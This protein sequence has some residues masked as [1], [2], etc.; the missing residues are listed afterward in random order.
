MNAPVR[1]LGIAFLIGIAAAI[2]VAPGA[3]ADRAIRDLGVFPGDSG[4]VALGINEAGWV[5]G[6]G[7]CDSCQSYTTYR[8]LLWANSVITDFGNLG[9]GTYS[10]AAAI[11]NVGQAVG[12]S[13]NA[14][15]YHRAFIWE[16]GTMRD[17][18]VGDSWSDAT[19][20]NDA[21]QVV[22]SYVPV[23][24]GYHAFLWQSG[25][26]TD[27]GA[28]PGL[29]YSYATGINAAGQVVGWSDSGDA[30]YMQAFVWENG[31]MTDLGTLPGTSQSSAWGINDEGQIV[32]WSG[33]YDHYPSRGVLWDHGHVQDLG[34]LREESTSA[35]AVNNAG[36]I[37][38]NSPAFLWEN[39]VMS[40]LG[41]LDPRGAAG[42]S[43]I[44]DA[45]QV[46]GSSSKFD[47]ST[48]GS[49]VDAVLWTTTFHNVAVTQGSASPRAADVGI[50][51][52][53]S[54]TV[55]NQGARPESF[56][57]TAYAGSVV[58]GTTHWSL[59]ALSSEWVS[60]TWNTTG[61]AP[62]SYEIRI[63]ISSEQNE[64]N[65]T[66]NTL[67]AGSVLLSV[68]VT[69]G[70]SATS[71]STDIGLSIA[72]TCRPIDGTPPFAFSWD[73]GDRAFAVGEAVSHAYGSPGT[74]KAT[75]TIVDGSG[76]QANSST[77]IAVSLLPAVTFSVGPMHA[78]AG[79]PL[80]FNASATGG[81][82]VRTYTWDFGDRSGGVGA[83]VIH[84]YASPGEYTASVIV[85]DSAG[86]TGSS[87]VLVTISVAMASQLV[88]TAT[89]SA[90]S[91]VTSEAITFT[92]SAS[93][94]AGG[95]YTY[96]WDFGDGTAATGPIVMHSFANPGSFTPKVTVVDGSGSSQQ[97]LLA[98]IVVRSSS[99]V[100]PPV[101]LATSPTLLVF[102]AGAAIVLALGVG[103]VLVWLRRKSR[104]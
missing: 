48:G 37:V 50:P 62:G 26:T 87:S 25:A 9:G 96:T 8:A 3:S 24:G 15:N 51:I 97:T 104:L 20:I 64:A 100:S 17:L 84:T 77:L 2:W 1:C 79:T 78:S 7:Y 40:S 22:G 4:S 46:V 94:G 38:G 39:G 69:A 45:G 103:I 29:P 52:T 82:G 73:F 44:N 41:G 5:V 13:T 34:Y 70:T 49:R 10:Q 54:A 76:N 89:G 83:T 90:V 47:P 11:N 36:Q 12:W 31:T 56:N 80:T 18:G 92:A 98:T 95:P 75:C 43:A 59:Q 65:L 63:E 85:L 19:D 53:I 21:G 68:P 58:V 101:A 55:E 60:F 72:F 27:L 28:I 86:G 16:N 33:G 66:D 71:I 99:A 35:R 57:V 67:T 6:Y 102:G 23:G 30:Y 32:G 14:S 42:A 61:V 91:V 93:G 88:V 74:K 81:S